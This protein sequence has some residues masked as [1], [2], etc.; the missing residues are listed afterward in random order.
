MTLKN[1]ADPTVDFF[2][3]WFTVVVACLLFLH[4]QNKL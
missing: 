1:T 4:R 2:G 3:I